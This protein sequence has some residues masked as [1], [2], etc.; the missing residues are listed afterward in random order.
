[1][2][3]C[4][5]FIM[6]SI[7]AKNIEWKCISEFVNRGT[8]TQ[9][10]TVQHDHARALK[11][12]RQTHTHGYT[13]K[14]RARGLQWHAAACWPSHCLTWQLSLPAEQKHKPIY[15]N[16]LYAQENTHTRTQMHTSPRVLPS[17]G[18]PSI[19]KWLKQGEETAGKRAE[20]SRKE[21]DLWTHSEVNAIPTLNPIPYP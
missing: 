5:D 3:P 15:T 14:P 1:M 6:Y 20:I 18:T 17:S 21:V 2:F 7:R 8:C 12:Q 9:A 11:T 4:N 13:H 16:I 19:P 10:H